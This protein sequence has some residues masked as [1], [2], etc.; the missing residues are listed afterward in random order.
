MS[1]SM[2]LPIKKVINKRVYNHY[3]FEP[4]TPKMIA[5]GKWKRKLKC[6]NRQVRRFI[7]RMLTKIMEE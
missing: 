5:R 3:D 4:H 7:N 2:R 1:I 6:K